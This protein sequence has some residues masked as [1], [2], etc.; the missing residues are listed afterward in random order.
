MNNENLE[1][2]KQELESMAKSIFESISNMLVEE[3]TEHN[4]KLKLDDKIKEKM[5]KARAKVN[6][7][8]K[9]QKLDA[10]DL[11]VGWQYWSDLCVQ[12]KQE[13]ESKIDWLPGNY[14]IPLIQTSSFPSNIKDIESTQTKLQS[15]R[16]LHDFKLKLHDFWQKQL[17]HRL[18]TSKLN[19]HVTFEQKEFLFRQFL[20]A[21]IFDCG[22]GTRADLL[23]I[24]KSLRETYSND[25]VSPFELSG[26]LVSVYGKDISKFACLYSYPLENSSYANLIYDEKSYQ[27][28]QIYLTPMS[29]LMLIRLVNDIELDTQPEKRQVDQELVQL[30]DS[31]INL[32]GELLDQKILSGLQDVDYEHAVVKIFSKKKFKLFDHLDYVQYFGTKNTLDGF[33]IALSKGVFNYSALSYSSLKALEGIDTHDSTQTSKKK[34]INQAIVD[35]FYYTELKKAKLEQIRNLNTDYHCAADIKKSL[36]RTLDVSNVSV[37]EVIAEFSKDLS[38][39]HNSYS[40]QQYTSPKDI[41][42]V[43]V[44][45]AVITWYLECLK[46]IKSTGSGKNKK[47]IKLS[48]LDTYKS[49]FIDELFLYVVSNDLD[50]QAIDEEEFEEIYSHILAVKSIGDSSKKNR[51]R[52][53]NGRGIKHNSY[54]YAVSNL[55]KFHNSLIRNFGAPRINYL[56][57]LQSTDLQVCRTSYVTPVMFNQFKNLIAVQTQLT[58]DQ[59]NILKVICILAYRTGLRLNEILGLKLSDLAMINLRYETIGH[60][61]YYYFTNEKYEIFKIFIHNNY[62]RQ[63]KT[64]NAKRGM[65]L[66]ELLTRDELISVIHLINKKMKV[67]INQNTLGAK[68]CLIF[69]E[70]GGGISHRSVSQLIKEMFDQ[71]FLNQVHDYS[72]HSFRHT[73][74][75]NLSLILKGTDSLISS[76]TDYSPDQVRKIKSY[77]LYSL[78]NAD[79]RTDL[80]KKL[81]HLIGH[82]SIEMTVNHYL[83][84]GPLLVAD[85]LC[86]E[87]SKISAKIVRA[88]LPV[89]LFNK[90]FNTSQVKE[91]ITLKSIVEK[92]KSSSRIIQEMIY[93]N[94]FISY[95]AEQ[96]VIEEDQDIMVRRQLMASFNH[97]VN[98]LSGRDIDA[99]IRTIGNDLAVKLY[100]NRHFQHK[101]VQEPESDLDR[102]LKYIYKN[103][104]ANL[105]VVENYQSFSTLMRENFVL[106][107]FEH[108][109]RLIDARMDVYIEC[110]KDYQ[111][112]NKFLR[113]LRVLDS[114]KNIRVSKTWQEIESELKMAKRK[115]GVN[116][117]IKNT[118]FK[119]NTC[120]KIFGALFLLCVHRQWNAK[121]ASGMIT[122]L[123]PV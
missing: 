114:S 109:I 71:L 44:Q 34:S 88:L 42:L 18:K 36:V 3:V 75:T 90:Q 57:Q 6:K 16:E 84:F 67:P 22:C 104:I 29:L 69:S 72:F 121:Q 13:V 38:L 23:A 66:D 77:L 2:L 20:L 70:E 86:I 122:Q 19:P 95:V 40:C 78:D 53:Q 7:Y 25:R 4:L 55:K 1:K 79:V 74:S 56:D 62:S 101:K 99:L 49:S 76:W 58:K 39:L 119:N 103:Q 65:C 32:N 51:K 46:E 41:A 12:N 59:K 30:L 107:Y 96:E 108:R 93:P 116:V 115:K 24:L 61:L 47:G 110:E 94:R 68:D 10:N 5:Y 52:S 83:H 82:S 98:V 117:E 35:N 26:G 14:N 27:V 123:G 113:K 33:L 11:K 63:L 92:L 120:Q 64:S 8:F 100:A 81:A 45:I 48:S 43:S 112:F 85:A 28:K 37:S 80:W 17:P 60:D 111:E 50:L 89:K 97:I 106:N 31:I 9:S 54:G 73:A 91:K 87:E 15:G 102:L 118:N 105:L 21:L